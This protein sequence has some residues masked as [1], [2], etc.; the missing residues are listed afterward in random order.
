[1]IKFKTFDIDDFKNDVKT[2]FKIDEYGYTIFTR[3]SIVIL[4]LIFIDDEDLVRFGYLCRDY[5]GNGISTY[6]F[7]SNGIDYSSHNRKYC[8]VD[9]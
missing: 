6:Y 4:N 3:G 5:H 2:D 9:V 8:I 7:R 1:M